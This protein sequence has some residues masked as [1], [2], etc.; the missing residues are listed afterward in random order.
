MLPVNGFYLV[1]YQYMYHVF[2]GLVIL[3]P[4]KCHDT[5]TSRAI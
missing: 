4:E 2:G 3:R 1:V 5:T